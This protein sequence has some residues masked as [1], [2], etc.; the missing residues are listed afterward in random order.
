MLQG[1]RVGPIGPLD[2]KIVIVGEAPG[3]DE[4]LRGLPFIGSS[5]QELD[6]M[7][8]EAGLLRSDCYITNVSKIRPPGNNMDLWFADTK[9]KAEELGYEKFMGEYVHSHIIDC[10]AELHAELEKLNPNIV[11]C[12]GWTACWAVTGKTPITAW[13]GSIME[14][15]PL[16]PEGTS[17]KVFKCLPTYHPANILRQ[18]ENRS[19]VVHDLGRAARDATFPEIRYPEYR[20]TIRPSYAHT[21][22]CLDGLLARAE[23]EKF[24]LAVDLETRHAHIACVGLAWSRLDAICIPLMCVERNEG[25]WSVEQE[26]EIV[27][28]LR[29]LLTHSNVKVVGQ[30]F[31]YDTQY[32]AKEWGIFIEVYFDTMIA[33]GVLFSGVERGL[34]F[35]SSMYC[36]FHQYWKDE[37]KE[38][39]PKLHSEDR[40]WRYNCIDAVATFECSDV[41]E[42]LLTAMKLWEQFNFQ[43][44]E[45][46]PELVKM[47]L[48]GVAINNKTRAEIAVELIAAI[49]ERH[50][51]FFNILGHDLNPRSTPQMRSLFYDRLRCPVVKHKKTHKATLNEEALEETAT[52]EPLLFPLVDAINEERSLS[53]FHNTFVKAPL[54]ADGRMRC[55]Y[56]FAE[57]YRLTSSK[58]AFGKGTNLQNIPDGSRSST[59]TM[60]NIRR[61]FVP[62]HGYTILEP[63]LAGADAQVV[64][65]EANDEIL[66]EIFRKRLK[67]HAE[68][69]KMVFEGLSGPDGRREP[70]YTRAK[71]GCHLLNYGGSSRTLSKTIAITQHEADLFKRRWFEIHPAILEWQ[72]RV[73]S[74]LVSRREVRN[75]FGYRR[76]YFDR[77][78]SVLPEALAW[79]PQSTVAC[80]IN[81]GLVNIVRFA[82][83]TLKPGIV[84]ILLQVHDS[85][86]L[87]V[88]TTYLDYLL[89]QLEQQLL[90]PLP[91][92]DPLT[93]PLG[94][95]GSP[96]SWGDAKALAWT[97]Q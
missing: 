51:Y 8:H 75:I 13:R 76:F 39:D 27:T 91:Y 56:G 93:I 9:K 92:P 44:H 11:I 58:N 29:K 78:Q 96:V 6:R 49:N 47:M 42:N 24:K 12:L 88:K 34:H 40:L 32:T 46:W 25:Y 79:V 68:N 26:L 15:L 23:Q 70:Y 1:I 95:K 81:R 30:N 97:K 55:Y 22:E 54:D 82:I 14:S 69:A 74:E 17:G 71:Q 2:A 73:E 84:E 59:M 18:W 5:G 60:P 86:V 35:L 62:D 7:L 89:P 20:F 52:A 16:G 90:I 10:V 64:A 61:L 37:G 19:I 38:W 57:T 45:L 77:I 72:R 66:K 85:L 50:A 83:R 21:I 94:L 41:M 65:W 4:E 63:D 43:M 33:Q 31:G 48:R 36:D 3:A 53:V 87:Q 67:L 80:V 28:R